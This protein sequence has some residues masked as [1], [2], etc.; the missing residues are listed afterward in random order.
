MPEEAMLV[1][2]MGAIIIIMAEL[3]GVGMREAVVEPGVPRAAL[4]LVVAAAAGRGLKAPWQNDWLRKW[5]PRRLF[6]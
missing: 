2:I 5:R 1:A 6:P 4:L 3:P